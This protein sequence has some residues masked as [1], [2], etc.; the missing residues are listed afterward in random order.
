M[1]VTSGQAA[2]VGVITREEFAFPMYQ[3]GLAATRGGWRL[4]S[5]QSE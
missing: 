1:K 5:V 4:L 3:E 2:L